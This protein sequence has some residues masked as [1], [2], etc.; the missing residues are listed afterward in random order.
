MHPCPCVRGVLCGQEVHKA[1]CAALTSVFFNLLSKDFVAACVAGVDTPLH[2]TIA[3]VDTI[4]QYKY[5][6]RT[7]WARPGPRKASAVC[8]RVGA[9]ARWG[10]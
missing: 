8:V 1:A 3:V 2:H 5:Q 9:G 4:V 7:P 10:S 6:V